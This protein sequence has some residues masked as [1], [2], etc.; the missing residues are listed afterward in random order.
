MQA[1]RYLWT[2]LT[3]S[4]LTTACGDSNE[5]P[6]QADDNTAGSSMNSIAEQYVRLALAIGQHDPDYVDAYYGPPE[7]RPADDAKSSLDDLV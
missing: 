5:R 3:M 1:R 7:W 2:V 6:G 4:M